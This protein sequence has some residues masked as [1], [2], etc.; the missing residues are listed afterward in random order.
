[1]IASL[2]KLGFESRIASAQDFAAFV[3]AEIPRWMAVVK[4]SGV[5]S[6]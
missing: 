2:K 3:A 1:M 6:Q 5:K 4:A